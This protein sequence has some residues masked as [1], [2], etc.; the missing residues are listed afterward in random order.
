MDSGLIAIV[1]VI[2][3]NI[4]SLWVFF[5]FFDTTGTGTGATSSH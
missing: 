1:L 3:L 5:T 2:V 4:V